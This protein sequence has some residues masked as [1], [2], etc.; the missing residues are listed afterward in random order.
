MYS[1]CTCF[2]C[3]WFLTPP[4]Q[5]RQFPLPLP[6]HQAH[7]LPRQQLQV[8]PRP[9]HPAH[10]GA[11][12]RGEFCMFV[13]SFYRPRWCACAWTNLPISF[14]LFAE[15]WAKLASSCSAGCYG[16]RTRSSSHSHDSTHRKCHV[17]RPPDPPTHRSRPWIRCAST[18]AATHAQWW[19]SELATLRQQYLHV[20]SLVKFRCMYMYMY[21]MYMYM[22]AMYKYMY[23]MCMYACKCACM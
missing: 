10:Q 19:R 23:A 1:T 12:T 14:P 7:V 22:Y 6:P 3:S 17:S 11:F 5:Y 4:S 18:A 15:H 21:A 9:P 13:T 16:S 20:V 2:T 8:L